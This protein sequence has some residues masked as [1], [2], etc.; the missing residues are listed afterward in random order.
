MWWLSSVELVFVV[1]SAGACI[2]GFVALVCSN[3]RMSRCS[4]IKC[5]CF[6]CIRENLS[7]DEYKEEIANQHH[8]ESASVQNNPQS[9][10]EGVV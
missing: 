8:I 4:K 3:M 5:C 6:E 10:T 9:Q 7:E 2:G 1:A